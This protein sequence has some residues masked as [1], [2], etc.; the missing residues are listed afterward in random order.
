MLTENVDPESGTLTLLDSKGNKDRMVYLPDDLL[1]S[2][3]M[4]QSRASGTP[5]PK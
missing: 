3:Y 1:E 4:K 5:Y 2:T